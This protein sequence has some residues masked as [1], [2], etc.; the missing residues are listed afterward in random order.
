MG[1]NGQ[2]ITLDRPCHVRCE[3]TKGEMDGSQVAQYFADGRIGDIIA[4]NRD[5]VRATSEYY[6]IMHKAG[7]V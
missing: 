2:R 6:E 5:D 7:M 3:I 4:Y 1:R